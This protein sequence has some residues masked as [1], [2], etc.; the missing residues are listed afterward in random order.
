MD[1]LERYLVA[2]VLVH[3]GVVLV[4]T[5]AHLALEIL[6]SPPDT[7][8]IVVVI[9]VGPV[10]ALPLLRI[11][12]VFAGGLL[13]VFMISAFAYGFQSHFLA[14]GPDR[15]SIIGTDPWTVAFVGSAIGIGVLEV[16]V[17]LLGITLFLSATRTPSGSSGRRT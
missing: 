13:A 15:V 14:P 9:L 16:A 8:F 1:R 4:H 11:S 3:L 10:A 17:A 6:P 5:V 2:A 7:G 12:R